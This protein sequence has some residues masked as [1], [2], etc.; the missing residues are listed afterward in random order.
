MGNLQ[1]TAYI[2]WHSQHSNGFWS[3]CIVRCLVKL[4]FFMNSRPHISHS[5]GPSVFL[6]IDWNRPFMRCIGIAMGW[7]IRLSIW[8]DEPACSQ[9]KLASLNCAIAL[10]WS[11]DGG[12]HGVC[13]CTFNS[14]AVQNSRVQFPHLFSGW[15]LQC[16]RSDR[17]VVNLIWNR[18]ECVEKYSWFWEKQKIGKSSYVLW[19]NQHSNGRSLECRCMCSV[20]FQRLRKHRPQSGH[21]CTASS[22]S[23]SSASFDSSGLAFVFFFFFFFR[24]GDNLA[25]ICDEYRGQSYTI[26]TISVANGFVSTSTSTSFSIKWFEAMTRENRRYK[27][28]SRL[29]YRKCWATFAVPVEHP[30]RRASTCPICPNKLHKRY[31]AIGVRCFQRSIGNRHATFAPS[32]VHH[33]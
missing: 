11:M 17:L 1:S 23:F 28:K 21:L 25:S 3:V 4:L 5:N 30:A 13:L 19:H 7:L 18:R 26:C 14:V 33:H 12:S 27:Q 2:L 29:T 6:R 31:A 10:A 24:G 15:F 22:T 20:R 8:D 9:L 32:T 16:T